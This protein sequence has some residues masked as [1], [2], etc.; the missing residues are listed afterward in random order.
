MGEWRD[1]SAMFEKRMPMLI[2]VVRVVSLK[3]MNASQPAGVTVQESH[4]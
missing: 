1:A 2:A 3:K 4:M